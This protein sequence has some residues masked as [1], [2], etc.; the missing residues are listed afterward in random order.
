MPRC[1]PQP[2][3]QSTQFSIELPGQKGDLK[4]T[5]GQS[6]DGC[7]SH[8]QNEC[9]HL[10]PLGGVEMDYREL[11]AK[12]LNEIQDEKVLIRI[13]KFVLRLWQRGA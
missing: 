4:S 2:L 5:W 8:G 10:F 11:I 7:P 6:L 1:R 12:V 13:Y 3:V 9:K